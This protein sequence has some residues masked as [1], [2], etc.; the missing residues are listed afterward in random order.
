MMKIIKH[1]SKLLI[2][3]EKNIAAIIVFAIFVLI[4]ILVWA[5]WGANL[6]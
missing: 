1:L 2:F 5:I 6:I 3:I 4:F